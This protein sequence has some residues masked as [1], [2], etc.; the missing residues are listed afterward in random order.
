MIVNLAIILLVGACIAYIIAIIKRPDGLTKKETAL[1]NLSKLYAD[2]DKRV[3]AEKARKTP[4]QEAP[5]ETCESIRPEIVSFR[6]NYLLPYDNVLRHSGFIGPVENLLAILDEHGDY[7]SVVNV[8]NDQE[9]RSLRKIHGS[10]DA[11]THITLLEHSFNV[12][13]ELIDLIKKQAKDYDV[14]IGKWIMIALGHDI[15]KIPAFR[16]GPYAM[17]DHAIISYSHLDRLLSQDLP[18]RKEILNAV[19]DHHFAAVAAPATRLLR[20]ADHAARTHEIQSVSQSAYMALQEAQAQTGA[21]QNN[22]A[23]SGAKVKPE[24]LDL[25]W[26]DKNRLL[27]MIESQINIIRNNQYRAF[28][29]R[30]GLVYVWLATIT[31]IVRELASETNHMEILTEQPSNIE[32]SVRHLLGEFFPDFIGKGYPGAN[33]RVLNKNQSLLTVGLYMPIKV[34][35]F[36]TSIT[37]LESRKKGKLLKIFEVQPLI[38]KR[39]A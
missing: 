32:F 36:S 24:A 6:Q 37:D 4:Q 26:M 22:N 25:S 39:N 1:A 20:R 35:A 13:R 16:V 30:T 33:F 2:Y 28:S 9:Y 29:M 34:E 3:T 31:E 10:Y 17:G 19:R 11:L 21:N 27:S 14:S 5:P 15:G 38:G 7:P 18:A 12:T 23:G 8:Q